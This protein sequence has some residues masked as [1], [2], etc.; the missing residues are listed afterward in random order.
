[1][2]REIRF[3]FFGPNPYKR[4]NSSWWKYWLREASP[5]IVLSRLRRCLAWWPV[6]WL[7]GEWDQS[8]LFRVLAMQFE[9]MADGFE[10]GI[11]VGWEN[12][13]RELRICAHLARR[14]ADEDYTDMEEYALTDNSKYGWMRAVA[15]LRNIHQKIADRRSDF[16]HK[17]STDLIRQH[18]LIAVEGL[19]VLGLSKGVLSKQVNDASWSSFFNMLR[20][21]AESAGRRF[22]E[23]DPRGTSQRC[24]SCGEVEK[25]ALSVRMHNCQNC[26]LSLHRDHN[27]A[28]N[29]LALG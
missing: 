28:L 29:I 26:G 18:D 15:Q 3:Q 1:M 25:K 7:G 17:L 2:K 4:F 8:Y 11:T 16:Q 27:A 9:R 10:N 12:Q 20:Y 24:S 21:K 13:V 6:H 23:A 22:V 14:L 5:R 19:N